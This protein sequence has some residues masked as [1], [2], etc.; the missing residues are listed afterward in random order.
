M[1]LLGTWCYLVPTS[2]VLFGTAARYD[3]FMHGYDGAIAARY[4]GMVFGERLLIGR[5]CIKYEILMTMLCAISHR[6][7]VNIP[8][9]LGSGWNMHMNSVYNSM[10]LRCH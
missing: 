2:L 1:C 9:P 10:I 3:P 8:A 5:M 4:I 7:R 6:T